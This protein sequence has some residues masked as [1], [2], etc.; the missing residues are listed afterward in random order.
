[1]NKFD[2]SF[3][4]KDQKNKSSQYGSTQFF[5]KL[6]KPTK[7]VSPQTASDLE[8]YVVNYKTKMFRVDSR[9]T[10]ENVVVP[11]LVATELVKRQD[12]KKYALKSTKK[13]V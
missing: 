1:M 7:F 2:R 13:D 8:Q 9:N 5:E 6:H 3:I 12:K 11:N 10:I 4:S